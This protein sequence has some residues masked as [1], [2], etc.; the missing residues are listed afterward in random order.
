M[1][2]PLKKVEVTQLASQFYSRIRILY[3]YSLEKNYEVR[4]KLDNL[5]LHS[6]EE[7]DML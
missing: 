6:E 7:M 3:D 4:L 2:F 5:N 1:D